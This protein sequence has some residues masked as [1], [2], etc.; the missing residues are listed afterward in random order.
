MLCSTSNEVSSS[1]CLLLL[2]FFSLFGRKRLSV[3]VR[4]WLDCSLELK[5]ELVSNATSPVVKNTRLNCLLWQA[6]VS[7][8]YEREEHVKPF[9]EVLLFLEVFDASRSVY[10]Q[11]CFLAS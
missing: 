1:F 3:D 11:A 2:L 4:D 6:A 5:V 8:H 10:G 7:R 9:G